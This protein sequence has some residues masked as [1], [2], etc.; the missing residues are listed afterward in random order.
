[1]NIKGVGQDT[2]MQGVAPEDRSDQGLVDGLR[3]RP[4]QGAEPRVGASHGLLDR[5]DMASGRAVVN[6]GQLTQVDDKLY[7]KL[8]APCLQLLNALNDTGMNPNSTEV[9][10]ARDSY[11]QAVVDEL[12]RSQGN[13][14]LDAG[15]ETAILVMMRAIEN[16]G[17]PAQTRKFDAFF[18]NDDNSV[19]VLEPLCDKI[20]ALL[21][22]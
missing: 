9:S 17:D 16:L 6:D 15:E 11:A 21:A 22:K 12:R 1:M 2:S 20:G 3:F 4:G 13:P 14:S 10:K 18:R 7:A 8:R 5:I 19:S